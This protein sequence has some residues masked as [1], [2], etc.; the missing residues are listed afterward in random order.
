MLPCAPWLWTLPPYLGGFQCCH[1]P[2]DF[3]VS[4][5]VQEGFDAA[6]CPAAL[7][8]SWVSGIK[9]NLVGLDMQLGSCVS[10]VRSHVTEAP[11]RCE[12]KRRHHDLQTVQ[13]GATISCYSTT[14]AQ[15]TTP[16]HGY[17]GDAT[18]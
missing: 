1:M 11:A 14:S 8:G 13:T 4:L 5:L 2:H 6:T 10:K 7:N 17:S 15:L 12:G 9:K 16:G 18:Q 3:R